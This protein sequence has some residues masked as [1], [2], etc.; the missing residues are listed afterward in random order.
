MKTKELTQDKDNLLFWILREAYSNAKGIEAQCDRDI[1][2]KKR[3]LVRLQRKRTSA[4]ETRDAAIAHAADLGWT[5]IMSYE[6]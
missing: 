2:D 4:A 6:M 1:E 3:E 5:L